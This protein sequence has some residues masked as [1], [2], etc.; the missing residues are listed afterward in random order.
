VAIF[1]KSPLRLSNMEV[2]EVNVQTL[3]DM[4][5][6]SDVD[7]RRA[8]RLGK[9]D[10]SEAVAILTDDNHST[11]FDTLP[12]LDAELKETQT[13]VSHEASSNPVGASTVAIPLGGPPPSYDEAS[14]MPMPMMP[15]ATCAPEHKTVSTED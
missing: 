11:G 4:G 3:L 12:E 2:N 8:L 15:T 7:I 5:F 14:A 9:N 13:S 1:I 10:L 6:P